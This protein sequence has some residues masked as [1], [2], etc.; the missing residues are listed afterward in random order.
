MRPSTFLDFYAQRFRSVE[1]NASFYK[2]PLA[3]TLE[4]WREATPSN[5]IFAAKASRY[6]TH[7][8]KLKDPEKSSS[9]FFEAITV[10]GRK[11]GPVLV[12]LPPRWQVNL[13]RLEAF[14]EVVP[15]RYR[16]A[17]EFRDES[18]LKAPVYKILERHGAA[19]CIY[20]FDGSQPPVQ[21]TAPF[22]Y[23]RLHGP[24]G[25][26]RGQY[27][28][29]TLKTWA[30]RLRGWREKGLEGYCYF[31][32]DESGFAFKDA[33]RLSAMVEGEHR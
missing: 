11:L 16:L 9:L 19:L 8:K 26:Y 10:L 5:F 7:R 31:D 12:Q 32:N 27:D 17:F 4:K 3:S 29:R 1:V 24:Y 15:K 22:V 25:K 2:L 20:D 23:V 13:V 33:L 28:E 18:W 6:L 21:V 30:R 14:L